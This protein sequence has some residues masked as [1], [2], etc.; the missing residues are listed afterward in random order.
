LETRKKVLNYELVNLSDIINQGIDEL[1]YLLTEKNIRVCSTVN[2]SEVV[3][4]DRNQI[5]NVIKSLIF[6]AYLNSGKNR[7]INISINK[8]HKNLEISVC[9]KG[10]RLEKTFSS[11]TTFST[12]GYEIKMLLC[13]KI[14]KFHSGKFQ[15]S[16][17][18]NTNFLTFT[19]PN[20]KKKYLIKP[21]MWTILQ[22]NN[23]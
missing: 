15:I 11:K 2:K 23:I 14:I 10:E 4:V 9:Y 20:V 21:P 12:V 17:N 8:R 16:H 18:N 13:N 6:T 1:G 19:L 5:L 7:E 3:S 22:P